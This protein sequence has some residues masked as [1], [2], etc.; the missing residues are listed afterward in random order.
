[1]RTH[2]PLRGVP[3]FAAAA[4]GVLL[5]HQLTYL[6]A[7]PASDDRHAA[8][9]QAGHDYLPFAG[10]AVLVLALAGALTLA[11]RLVSAGPFRA[12]DA[13]DDLP[14]LAAR[15]WA[16]QLVVFASMEVTERLG[17]HAPLGDLLAAGLLPI[18]VL[19]LAVTAVLGAFVLRWLH[20]VVAVGVAAILRRGLRAPASVGFSRGRTLV[21]RLLLLAGAAGVRGPPALPR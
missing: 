3:T 5:G 12:H 18:G 11:L 4:A 14:R 21:P 9:A 16:I 13:G 1:M 15:L 20:R 6:L 2:R 17:S 7:H 19:C 10:K 8:L